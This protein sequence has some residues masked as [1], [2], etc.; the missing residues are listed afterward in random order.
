MKQR[1]KSRDGRLFL[2]AFLYG[3][4]KSLR[5]FSVPCLIWTVVFTALWSVCQPSALWQ[6]RL[7]QEA[8][9]SVCG[10]YQKQ[11]PLQVD[12]TLQENTKNDAHGY[13]S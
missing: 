2:T 1:P 8:S 4:L 13:S 3:P 6:L 9:L 7:R 12:R 10:A 5:Q 11:V